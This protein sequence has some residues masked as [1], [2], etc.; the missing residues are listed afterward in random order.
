MQ[1]RTRIVRNLALALA[2]LVV[3]VLCATPLRAQQKGEPG[4]FDF[5]LLDMPWGPEFCG[6]A[7]VS[8]E[9]HAQRGFVLHGLWPQNDDGS[10]PVFCSSEAGPADPRANLDITPD[11]ALLKHEWTKH[12]T[13]SG[14]GP[15]RFFTMEHRAFA[16]MHIPPALQHARQA[17]EMSPGAI[18]DLFYKANPQMPRG[19]LLVSCRQHQL[20]AVEA[21]FTRD[22]RPMRCRALTS[23]DEPKLKIMLAR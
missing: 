20:T 5:Y 21:C 22:L 9:C 15:Q 2:A 8:H 18:L 10:Y 7:D 12:G 11:L 17:L 16:S 3:C 23:C 19:S 13:C 1:R 6:I 4:H 14:V